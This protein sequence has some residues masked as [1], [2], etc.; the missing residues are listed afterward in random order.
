MPTPVIVVGYDAAW[1]D[2]FAEIAKSLRAL[3]GDAVN[4][5]DHVGSTAVP[6]L[7]AKPIID[8][9]VTLCGREL[10]EPACQ[11]IVQAGY[12]ARGNR[13]DDDMWAFLAKREPACRVYLCPPGNETHRK[14][15]VFR[16]RLRQDGALREAYGA[17]KQ[18]LSRRFFLEGDAYT[19][20]KR[21]FIEAVIRNAPPPR[22]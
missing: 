15:L 3:L 20:A 21:D 12:G 22:W 10:I 13:Y 4:A 8:I 16:D 19:A 17:L 6:G 1:P 7:A 11:R 18:Q 5:I 14:R 9:D 2:L